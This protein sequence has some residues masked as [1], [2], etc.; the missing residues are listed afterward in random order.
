[1]LAGALGLSGVVVVAWAAFVN[2]PLGG[3]PVAVVATKLPPAIPTKRDG[4]RDGKQHTRHDGLAG[5]PPEASGVAAKA[6]E[7]PPPGSKTVTII[8]GSSGAGRKSL[9]R[10]NAD[11]NTPKS[12][13]DPKLIEATRHSA[14]PKLDLTA[15]AH[16]PAIHPRGSGE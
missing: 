14:I 10:G 15:R 4:D 7:T 16:Q 12:L 11:A 5:T 9:F 6:V 1:L 13:L 8:D 3:E 2:D